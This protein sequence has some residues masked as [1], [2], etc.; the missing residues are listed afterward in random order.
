LEKLKPSS[1]K[2]G[3]ILKTLDQEKTPFFKRIFKE[4]ANIL[5]IQNKRLYSK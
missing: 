2:I 4:I 5:Y 1:Q 3:A